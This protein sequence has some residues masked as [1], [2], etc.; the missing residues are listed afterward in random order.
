[1]RKITEVSNGAHSGM[2]IHG[3]FSYFI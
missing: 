1:M 2:Y 3:T